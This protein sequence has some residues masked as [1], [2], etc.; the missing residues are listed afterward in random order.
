MFKSRFALIV[1]ILS[2]ALATLAVSQPFSAEPRELMY[3]ARWTDPDKSLQSQIEAKPYVMDSATR[4]YIAWGEAL[5]AKRNAEGAALNAYIANAKN[6]ECQAALASDLNLDSATRSYIAW[7]YAMEAKRNAA[8][9]SATRSYIA[10]GQALEAARETKTLDSAT[11]SYIAWGQALQ[12]QG[13]M[14][15]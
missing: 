5:A 15:R 14:C 10:W 13:L 11:R 7:G 3:A 2:L 12:A 1:A 4:S 9:D 6:S 8:M